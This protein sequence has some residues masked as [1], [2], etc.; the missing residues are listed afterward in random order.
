M[1]SMVG[2][3]PDELERVGIRLEKTGRRISR[4][5]SRLQRSLQTTPWHG[6][7]ADRF[8]Q[9]FGSVH[10][11]AMAEAGA[12][13]DE[14]YETLRR[15]AQQQ[16]EASGTAGQSWTDRIRNFLDRTGGWICGGFWYHP[17]SWPDL[18]PDWPDWPPRGGW[19]PWL[20]W[21]PPVIP[22]CPGLPWRFPDMWPFD[23]IAPWKPGGWWDDI[24]IGGGIIGGWAAGNID[25]WFKD[26]KLGPSPVDP[27]EFD[28]PRDPEIIADPP[29]PPPSSGP[30]GPHQFS[31]ARL[32][33]VADNYV[34][35]QRQAVDASGNGWDQPGQCIKWVDS[36]LEEAGLPGGLPGGT[37]PFSQFERIGGVRV[38][39][40][41]P[42]D[43]MQRA[44]PGDW[45]ESPHTAIVKS[46]NAATGEVTLVEG[47]YDYKGTVGEFTYTA[48][49]LAR[50]GHEVRYYRLGQ[51]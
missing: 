50:P 14:A 4:A 35:Q 21:T 30:D 51:V 25:D 2:A 45:G 31:Q 44:V 5:G 23:D 39:H 15:N 12:F 46:Y 47:N 9:E 18:L 8:R 20:P 11:R 29:P 24:I 36:W 19:G 42:G 26:P 41:M 43:V 17:P 7:N 40:P 33:D 38:D 13:L 28:P 16:R 37:D 32:V 34:G 1:S 48:K 22:R 27:I 3:D 6:G 10:A 49:E